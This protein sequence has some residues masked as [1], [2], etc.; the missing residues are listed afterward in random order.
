MRRWTPGN[1]CVTVSPPLSVREW[2]V[3]RT[4]YEVHVPDRSS[5]RRQLMQGPDLTRSLRAVNQPFLYLGVVRGERNG[6]G[7]KRRQVMGISVELWKTGGMSV[8][9]CA[10]WDRE[11][12]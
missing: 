12:R 7:K 2:T 8:I 10:C 9:H 11:R 3:H 5:T 1:K 6:Q 4:R